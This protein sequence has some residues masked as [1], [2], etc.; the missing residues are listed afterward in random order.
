MDIVYGHALFTVIAASGFDANSGLPGI[1]GEARPLLAITKRVKS[2]PLIWRGS[3]LSD[4]LRYSTY[5]TRAWTMQEKL[6]S[7]RCLYITQQQSYFLCHSGYTCEDYHD[8]THFEKNWIHAQEFPSPENPLFML[9]ECKAARNAISSNVWTYCI[10]VY[11]RLVRAYTRRIL[12]YQEDALNAF[13]GILGMLKE[14]GSGDFVSALPEAILDMALLWTPASSLGVQRRRGGSFPS[15]CWTGWKGE[16]K[17]EPLYPVHI[18]GAPPDGELFPPDHMKMKF[19][20]DV[21][22]HL[23]EHLLEEE[24][25][26]CR[27]YEFKFQSEINAFAV[28][29]NDQVRVIRPRGAGTLYGSV[30]DYGA[31]D[32]STSRLADLT[33]LQP[34]CPAPHPP[35]LH[36]IAITIPTTN[37]TLANPPRDSQYANEINLYYM[38]I[39][40]G[41]LYGDF[42]TFGGL[43]IFPDRIREFILCSRMP[44]SVGT[45]H[46]DFHKDLGVQGWFICNVMLIEYHLNASWAERVVVGMLHNKVW[47]EQKQELKYIVLG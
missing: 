18:R 31:S 3:E 20:G 42:D 33:G 25:W 40:C 24:L 23:R 34:A 22:D 35:L 5:D 39:Q 32:L 11:I 43:G 14:A 10:Y 29:D 44:C 17:Y 27:H 21:G 15:W 13:S 16:V 6:I 30:T 36:F 2:L 4:T 45:Y 8:T 28:E 1:A 46:S 7:R 9:H 26:A 47:E 19:G 38:G 41:K 37:F 12:T